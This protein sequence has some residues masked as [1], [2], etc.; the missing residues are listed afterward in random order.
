[1]SSS[2]HQWLEPKI[3]AGIAATSLAFWVFIELA[4]NVVDGDAHLY[5]TKIMLAVHAYDPTNLVWL[6]ELFRDITGLGGVGVLGLLIVAS[7]LFLVVSNKRRTALFVMLA[8][9][10]GA[11]LSTL[12]KIGFD[13]PRPDLIPHLTH[14]YSTSFPSGHAMVSA[15]VYMTLGALLAREVSGLWSKVYIMTVA[16]II[17]GLVGFSRVYLG[18]HW[19][20]D[21]I[22]GWAAG[23]SW[24]VLCWVVANIINLEN[25]HQL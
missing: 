4:E 6:N 3:L 9:V 7:S 12:L 24:A 13:R 8:T 14:A 20:S 21:I 16:I 2:I 17:T 25:G 19:P 1:M 18:V 5:D 22:A 15:V 11:V 10:S 23:A